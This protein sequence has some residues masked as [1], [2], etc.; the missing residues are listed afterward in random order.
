MREHQTSVFGEMSALATATGSVNLGQGFPDTDGPQS[1]KDAAIRAITEGRGNQYPMPMNTTLE[2]RPTPPATS[3]RASSRA[4]AT[5]CS[6]ISAVDRF[7]VS[8]A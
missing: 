3:P 8:P 7:R 5:T 4:P 6:T 2:T 1:V